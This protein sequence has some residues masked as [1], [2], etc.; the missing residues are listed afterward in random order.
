MRALLVILVA[1]AVGRAQAQTAPYV[2]TTLA[3]KAGSSG[4]TNEPGGA[5]R[6]NGPYGIAIDQ[7]DNLYIADTGNS[8]IRKIAFDGMVS[9]LAGSFGD[10]GSA[11]G[12]GG[13]ARFNHPTG[14]A[15][16]LSGNVYVADWGNHTIRKITPGGTVSTIAGLAGDNGTNDGAG[17]LA[18]FNHPAGVAVDALG[19]V[20]VADEWNHTIRKLTSDGINWNVTTVAGAPERPG[21]GDGTNYQAR[22]DFP[23]GIAV[24]GDGNLY[25]ADSGN[26]TIRRAVQVSSVWTVNTVAGLSGNS[27]SADGLKDAARFNE[28]MGVAVDHLQNLYVTDFGNHTIRMITPAGVVSTLAGTAGGNG[29]ANGLAGPNVPAWAT[30]AS[31]KWPAG[32]AVDAKSDVYIA[33]VGNHAIR[34]G[35]PAIAPVILDQPK[36]VTTIPGADAIFTATVAGE[37]PIIIQWKLNGQA[38]PNSGSGGIDLSVGEADIGA[39]TLS[40]EATSPY[41]SVTSSIVQLIV[42]APDAFV[43]LAGSGGNPGY[44]DGLGPQAQFNRPGNIAL[45]GKGNVYVA[46]AF[47]D[48]IRKITPAGVTT[49]IAG[50]PG[51]AGYADDVGTNALFRN[52]YGITFDTNGDLFVADTYNYVIRKLVTDGTNW[53]VSTFA[54]SPGNAGT[55]DGPGLAGAKFNIPAYVSAD[56]SNNLYVGDEFTYYNTL[57]KITPD[58]NVTTLNVSGAFLRAGSPVGTAS[59]KQGNLFAADSF[60]NI[61]WKNGDELAGGSTIIPGAVDGPANLARFNN[62]FDVAVDGSNN[63]YVAD[64]GSST[65]LKIANGLVTTIAG[66]PPPT[67][68]Y[69]DVIDPGGAPIPG[70]F[71]DGVGTNALFYNPLGIAVDKSGLVYVAD[72]YNHAIRKEW[73]AFFIS[74]QPGSQTVQVNSDVTFDVIAAAADSDLTYQWFKNGTAIDGANGESYTIH[75]AQSVNAGDYSV[76]VTNG[77]NSLVSQTATLKVLVPPIL[78]AQPQNQTVNEGDSAEFNV[79]VTGTTPFSYQWLYNGV[80]LVG[81]TKTN[82]SIASAATNDIGIYSVAVT[83][84]GGTVTSDDA[85]L[86]FHKPTIIAPP[87]DQ[88]VAA[89]SSVTFTVVAGG[90]GPLSYQWLFDDV[91][92]TGATSDT[93]TISD[94]QLANAGTYTAVVSNASGHPA[95]SDFVLNI[96]GNPRAD[97]FVSVSGGSHVIYEISPDGTQG[98]FAII[99]SQFG[100]GVRFP[101]LAFDG[102]GN[103][104]ACDEDSAYK[105]TPDGS[106]SFFS[107][108]AN[109]LDCMAFDSASNLFMGFM[110]GLIEKQAPDGSS[111]IYGFADNNGI[112]F[113]QSGFVR[114]LAVDSAGRVFASDNFYNHVDRFDP[115]GNGES[116]VTF[117]S[118]LSNPWGIAFD[119]KGNL[120]VTDGGSGSIYKYTVA[121]GVSLGRTVFASG[122]TGSPGYIYLA[123]DDEDNV[124]ASAAGNIY[125]FT[126]DGSRTTIATGLFGALAFAPPTMPRVLFSASPTNGEAPLTVHFSAPNVDSLGN[127]ITI[128]NWNFG[129]GTTGSGQNATHTYTAGGNFVAHLIATNNNG[130]AVFGSGPLISVSAPTIDFTATPESGVAPLTVQFTSPSVDSD[131]HAITGWHWDFG[132]GSTAD[133]QNPLHIYLTAGYFQPALTATND[134]G[135]TVIGSG[136]SVEVSLP[137]VTFTATPANGTAPLTVQFSTSPVDTGGNAITSWH[138]DFGDGTIG[139]GQNPSHTYTDDGTFYPSLV[140][141][142]DADVMVEGNSS[143]ISITV[144]P[145][146]TAPWARSSSPTEGDLYGVAAGDHRL[147]AVGDDNTIITST[148]GLNWSADTVSAPG[149]YFNVVAYG[150]GLFATT[151]DGGAIFTSADGTNWTQQTSPTTDGL[152]GMTFG[153]GLWVAVGDEGTIVTSPDGSHWTEQTNG[154]AAWLENVTFDNGQFVAVGG[155]GEI[156]ASTDGTNWT[157]QTL[158]ANGE[159]LSG[160]TSGNGLFVA[161]GSDGEIFTSPDGANWTQQNSG[162]DASLYNVSYGNGHFIAVGDDGAILLSTDATNWMADTPGISDALYAAAY[163]QNGTFVIV[164]SAGTILFNQSPQLGAVNRLAGNQIQFSLTGLDGSTAVIEATPALSPANWRP[165]ATNIIS[166][167]TV[168]FTDVMTNHASYYRARVE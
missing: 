9:T 8:A 41:G 112:P 111:S 136:P 12:T 89:G 105:F 73:P 81:Q 76:A 164:G 22:F 86:S 95:S 135:V 32:I 103:L 80:P 121:N 90:D 25:I 66:N 36:S 163:Y 52:P 125:K 99:S 16:D 120:F 124:F 88:T 82:L 91:A 46:D 93:Y 59:D 166:N 50:R 134:G 116:G 18:R 29:S 27:G 34:E 131:G 156:C 144:W 167:G 139:A 150:N 5:A 15:V 84:P 132:D 65:I 157:H 148:D 126:P 130:T 53:T 13:D 63:V 128:W 70:G 61:I 101:A 153:N 110:S 35:A 127:A 26:N 11:D 71:A 100:A 122:L 146:L 54:G 94:P 49:T 159:Q 48:V 137:T 165:V 149:S 57:R 79:A 69:G 30:P 42:T 23:A 20:Y 129:D 7:A 118:G 140:A 83:G 37:E 44:A 119:S 147:V 43:T 14:V 104:L 40:L 123:I 1:L 102:A 51:V 31:F 2:F 38:L 3:G 62:P 142:N 56:A 47:N 39:Y 154:I 97:L 55:N 106:Q 72:T 107:S 74:A 117:A 109:G 114:G 158:P 68:S 17:S 161:V 85:L 96:S 145:P 77:M 162:G 19:N 151:G 87:Q 58:G 115:P 21:G 98:V 113:S 64:T 45:D 108:A 4:A 133:E 155:F 141:T 60:L 24:D 138:W 75:G 33:E 143:G 152:W 67:N 92:I 6:F 168:Q 10:A 160:I 78:T 28:P